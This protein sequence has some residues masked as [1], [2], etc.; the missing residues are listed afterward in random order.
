M[1]H[2]IIYAIT[3]KKSRGVTRCCSV[4]DRVILSVVVVFLL[5]MFAIKT[6]GLDY[7]QPLVV[8]RSQHQLYGVTTH[9]LE[10]DSAC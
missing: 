5:K 3:H 8:Y 6:F 1:I 2:D 9:P 4:S 7:E 10:L